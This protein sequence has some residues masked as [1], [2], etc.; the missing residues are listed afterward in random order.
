MTETNHTL[1]VSPLRSLVA[2]A[3]C[4]GFQPAAT[5]LHLTQGAVSQH[6]RRLEAAVGRSLFERHGRRSLFTA[7]GEHLLTQARRILALHDETLRGFGV[8]TKQTV[9]IGAT[10]HGAAQILPALSTALESADGYRFRFRIDRGG[11]L[12]R[13][14]AAGRI[15]L[16]LL[17]NVPDDARAIPVGAL[18]LTWHSAPGWKVPPLP[19]PVP[20]VA[21]D[22]PCALRSRALETLA[23]RGIPAVIGAEAVQL[24]GVQAAVRA[25][26]GVALMA[27]LGQTP[28][29]LIARHDLPAAE[30]LTLYVCS[31]PG[32]ADGVARLVADVIPLRS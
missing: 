13:G 9:T 7:D 26:L 17:L 30:P 4:G 32:I 24:A 21:F 8:E 22:S 20:L 31:R 14:L 18:D 25:G 28:D 3:E 23:S 1:D 5:H 12:H 19:R 2:I 10:E 27:T 29:G 11:R 15:D 16:A 6:M